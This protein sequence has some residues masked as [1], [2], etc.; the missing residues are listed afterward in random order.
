VKSTAVKLGDTCE[1]IR[2]VTFEKS[3]VSNHSARDKTPILRAGNIG[4]ELDT[5]NDLVWVP[6]ELVAKEQ[7]FQKNDIVIC[8]SS[9]SSEVVG[10]TATVR[11]AVKASV[12]SFCGIIRPKKACE[13]RYLSFFFRSSLFRSH[14]DSIARGANIQNLRFS[15]IEEIELSIPEDA[16]RVAAILERADR[17][18][19]LRRYG[20][21]MVEALLRPVFL[22]LFGD[23]TYNPKGWDTLSLNRLI[24]EGPQNGIYKA[25]SAYGTGTPILRIDAF[26][27][28]TVEDLSRLKRVRL[29]RE[30][31]ASYGLHENDIVIN[32]VNSR[33]FLGKS[34][35][36]PDLKEPTVF[37]SNMMRLG[38]DTG[39]VNPTYLVN[40]L[41][42]DF[43]R[44]QIQKCGKDAVNQASINQE[45]VKGFLIRVPPVSLQE[46]FMKV[47]Q[48]LEHQRGI[49]RESLR[50]AE[51]L[52]QTLL[53]RAFA[54]GL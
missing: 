15:Q 42:T 20:V 41:Q 32:R 14:R 19:R 11:D 54:G 5:R 48:R 31:V 27:D 35:I 25:A 39:R 17:L 26:Y 29:S 53:H 21:G 44:T 18:L 13:S 33:P 22:N 34:A 9:G 47:A 10:K 3:D 1:F 37:E 23:A 16:E 52:F 12:G 28:G 6:D 40:Y 4:D 51:H 24:V 2:G 7:L 36:I 30:E 38:V 46:K 43:V 50:Q 49:H 45:D 8:M